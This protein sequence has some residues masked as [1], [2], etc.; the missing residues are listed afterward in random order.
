M[1]IEKLSLSW[2][3]EKIT[4]G[5]FTYNSLK[6]RFFHINIYVLQLKPHSRLCLALN[7]SILLK[8]QLKLIKAK[9]KY[10]VSVWKY[11]EGN[12]EISN[13]YLCRGSWDWNW[14]LWKT[15]EPSIPWDPEPG[16]QLSSHPG[17]ALPRGH[18]VAK[19]EQ[20]CGREI[21]FLLTLKENQLS[22]CRSLRTEKALKAST[23]AINT[24]LKS[25]L[26]VKGFTSN[27]AQWNANSPQRIYWLCWKTTA[28]LAGK[29]LQS[30]NQ[31][32][33]R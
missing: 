21:W 3:K 20:G 8:D 14:Q 26:S 7:I 31:H 23:N 4:C 15:S 25:W 32:P 19:R 9:P 24:L 6:K 12:R 33:G 30:K 17:P 5:R 16:A 13:N 22:F 27:H 28:N 11:V 10:S 2:I 18:A 1:K 29:L